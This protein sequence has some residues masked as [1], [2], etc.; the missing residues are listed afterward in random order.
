MRATYLFKQEPDT[1]VIRDKF[2]MYGNGNVLMATIN[3][4][5]TSM[6][7]NKMGLPSANYSITYTIDRDAENI[8]TKEF[9]RTLKGMGGKR[10]R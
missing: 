5:P 7:I 2:G 4:H 9:N 6:V 8:V 3:G 10:K 1:S